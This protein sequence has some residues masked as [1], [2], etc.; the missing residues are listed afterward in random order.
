MAVALSYAGS[1]HTARDCSSTELYSS[2]TE[3]HYEW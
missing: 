1:E 3:P 2:S